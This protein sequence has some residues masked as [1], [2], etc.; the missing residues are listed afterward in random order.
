MMKSKLVLTIAVVFFTFRSIDSTLAQEESKSVH[1]PTVEEDKSTG[2]TQCPIELIAVSQG[3]YFYICWDCSNPEE[4]PTTEQSANPH[5]TACM[6]F[7][8]GP[9]TC[10][11]PHVTPPSEGVIYEPFDIKFEPGYQKKAVTLS[12]KLNYPV[13]Q[14]NLRYINRMD[15][16]GAPYFVEATVN[17]DGSNKI[18]MAVHVFKYSYYESDDNSEPKVI[19][20]AIAQEADRVTDTRPDRIEEERSDL[21]IDLSEGVLTFYFREDDESDYERI[22]AAASV[23]DR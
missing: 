18:G 2:F 19:R 6:T 4:E 12:Q 15:N 8:G 3:V 17:G 5:F 21:A 20:V 9:V 1:E 22:Y 7:P 11:C 14:A 16:N 13:R 23:L 10:G